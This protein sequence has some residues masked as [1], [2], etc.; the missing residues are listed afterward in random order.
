MKKIHRNFTIKKTPHHQNQKRNDMAS[1]EKQLELRT[2]EGTKGQNGGRE[3][4]KRKKYKN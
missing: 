4:R 1:M 2:D 3:E